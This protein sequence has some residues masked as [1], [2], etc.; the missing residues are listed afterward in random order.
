MRKTMVDES[1][2]YHHSYFVQKLLLLKKIQK[3]FGSLLTY[4]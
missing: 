4:S 1:F 3:T 2:L